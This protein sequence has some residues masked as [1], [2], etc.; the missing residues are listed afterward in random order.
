MSKKFMEPYT[1]QINVRRRVAQWIHQVEDQAIR[2]MILGRRANLEKHFSLALS[3]PE[4]K[5]CISDV[6]CTKRRLNLKS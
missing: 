1:W 2:R 3:S 5:E 6:D 4:S